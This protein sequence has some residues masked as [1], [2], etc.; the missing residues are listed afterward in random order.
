MRPCGFCSTPSKSSRKRNTTTCQRGL[1]WPF[2]AD[3]HLQ[4]LL[5]WVM[6]L[7]PSIRILV[8]GVKHV[9]LPEVETRLSLGVPGV[10]AGSVLGTCS[11]RFC[12]TRELQKTKSCGMETCTFVSQ[13][14]RGFPPIRGSPLLHLADFCCQ[15]ALGFAPGAV[16]RNLLGGGGEFQFL[17][18]LSD[19][20]GCWV[21][22]GYE[23]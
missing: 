21:L 10:P 17:R 22:Y 6:A 7:A 3:T 8:R 13:I 4:Q 2:L 14:S 12:D 19:S 15:L 11:V 23:F 9:S 1:A 18:L 20:K 5:T 16:P